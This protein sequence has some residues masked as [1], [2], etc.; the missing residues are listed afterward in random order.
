M[1]KNLKQLFAVALALSLY[2]CARQGVP[3]GGPK[4]TT[5][6]AID[7]LGSTPNFATRLE[8]KRLELKFNEWVTLSEAAAQVVVSPPLVKRPE[9]LLRGKTV[10][11]KFDENEK[12]RENTT[13][14]INFGT[15]VKDL[16]EG[17]AAKDLRFVFSTGDFID[18]LSSKGRVIDAFT[19]EP[20]ENVAVMLYDNLTDSV[21]RNDRPYY[22]S[23]SDKTGVYEI[24]NVKAG[25][26][27]VAAV[28]DLDQ[29]LRWDGENERIGYLDTALVMHD[30]MRGLLLL[31]LF[32]NTPKFRLGDKSLNSF[33]VVKLKFND[34]IDSAVI[35]PEPVAGLKIRLE[36]A[37]DSVLV[38]YDLAA[39]AAWKLFVNGDTLSIK[40]LSREDF[41][42]KHNFHLAADVPASAAG[43]KLQQTAPVV[44]APVKTVQQN[45]LKPLPLLFNYPVSAVDTG[46]W[47]IISDSAR[48]QAFGVR[49]DSS[50]PR[51]ALLELNW[52]PGKSY[53]LEIL[54]GAVTDFWGQSNT[55]TLRRLLNV[56]TDKQLGGL[57]LRL[58]LLRPG[59]SYV[60]QLLDGN[61]VV[62]ER[63]IVAKPADNK[64]VFSKLNVGT[65]TARLIEDTNG[66]GRWDTGD[67]WKHRQAEPVL[68]K[69]LESLR[70]NW[71][72]EATLSLNTDG[73]EKKKRK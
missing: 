71:E 19:G 69:K 60:V 41:L 24:R 67:Y 35:T 27:K 17:N 14:T 50:M 65:Y 32:K 18:S 62:E 29:N 51:Q 15:A 39:P 38:W 5:P 1:E 73:E 70:A 8:P 44:A 28:E 37:Q 66:N 43:R 2:A 16:H 22:F 7:T 36:K 59:L 13:Y 53:S 31:R 23:R 64:L 4:D 46:K 25:A 21:V 52:L 47:V 48:V 12:F 11:V 42:A 10:I 30:S 55:D 56:P 72:V 3:S 45:P 54:P 26:F 68:S 33:G 49:L 6:P 61:T 57:N 40:E 9:V 58:E 63:R 34:Q 20:I